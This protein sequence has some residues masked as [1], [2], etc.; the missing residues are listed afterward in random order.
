MRRELSSKASVLYQYVIP[1]A[2]LAGFA[3]PAWL[4]MQ[5]E[6]EGPAVLWIQ[7]FALVTISAMAVIAFLLS[8]AKRVWLDNEKLIVKG[9][10]DE[11]VIPLKDVDSVTSTRF[12]NPDQIHI[13]YRS[14]VSDHSKFFFYPPLRMVH[15]LTTHPMAEEIQRLVHE[16][17]SPDTPYE[18]QRQPI[19]WTRV[20][21]GLGAVLLLVAFV[22][23]A[24]F[25]YM[26]STAPYQWSLEKIRNNADITQRLGTPLESGWFVTGSI[27]NLGASG[28]TRLQYSVSG[29]KG[30]GVA[31]VTGVKEKDEWQYSRAGVIIDGVYHSVLDEAP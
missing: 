24:A 5:L 3:I 6:S 4:V 31:R 27:N 30:K 21:L 7:V 19:E 16:V 10:S 14:A 15:F 25:S 12:W 18:V 8:R 20:Y 17:N 2:I 26:K 28:S 13:T 22:N 11:S 23:T 29:P 9:W 1:V